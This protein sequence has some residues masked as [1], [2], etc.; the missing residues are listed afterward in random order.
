MKKIS[1]LLLLGMVVAALAATSPV[2]WK[3]TSLK[4][5]EVKANTAVPLAF[6]FT[7]SSDQPITV[8]QA[9][10]SCGCTSV[11][12]PK[13]PIAPGAKA[14]ISASFRSGKAGKFKKNIRILTNQSSEYT[15]LYFTGEVVH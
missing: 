8:M 3:S 5:G 6:E 12:Y 13:E 4:L 2:H 9:K 10:G 7:N 11:K 1:C 15:Y 14:T